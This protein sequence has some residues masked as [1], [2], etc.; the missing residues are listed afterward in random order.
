MHAHRPEGGLMADCYDAGGVC[1]FIR[2]IDK[3]GKVVRIYCPKCHTQTY[4]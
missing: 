3:D 1:S 2:V 4:P